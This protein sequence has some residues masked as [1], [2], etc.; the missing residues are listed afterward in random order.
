MTG[1]G[2][3]AMLLAIDAAAVG[4]VF[5]PLAEV[6]ERVDFAERLLT[7]AGEVNQLPGGAH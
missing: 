7:G 1:A 2:E 4:L 6:E 3:L 5:G